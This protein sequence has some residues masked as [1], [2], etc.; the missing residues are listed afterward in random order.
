MVSVLY[1]QSYIH[2]ALDIHEGI[3]ITEIREICCVSTAQLSLA[4]HLYN[5]TLTAEI[6]Q[7]NIKGNKA[8]YI[9]HELLY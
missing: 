1:V 2:F 6:E 8:D 3:G 9:T 4:S 7:G 5:I